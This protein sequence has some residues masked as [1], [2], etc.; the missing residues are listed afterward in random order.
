MRYNAP[1]KKH[2]IT[3]GGMPGSG[4]SSTGKLLAENLEYTRLSSGDFFREMAHTRGMTVEEINKAAENDPTIDHQ[5]DEWIRAQG[6]KENIVMDSRTAFHWIP[7]SFKVFLKLDPHIAALRTYEHIKE[8]GRVGQSAMSPEEVYKNTLKRIE[9]ERKRYET[10]YGI[11]YI[12]ELQYDLVVDT[13]PN[14]LSTVVAII[15]QA[16]K[17][18]L[19]AEEK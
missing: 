2:I 6:E 3:L 14:D 5:T 12:D 17:N 7:D 13:G 8:V 9:S 18:W 15:K 1:M 10:L 16:Y 11:D 19:A 4:K